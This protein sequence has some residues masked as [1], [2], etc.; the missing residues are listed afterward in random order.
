MHINYRIQTHEYNTLAITQ[1]VLSELNAMA[2]ERNYNRTL[3]RGFFPQN[4]EGD[5]PKGEECD[6]VVITGIP[7]Q[8]EMAMPHYHAQ[9]RLV[10]PHVRGVFKVPTITMEEYVEVFGLKTKDV[11]LAGF[12]TLEWVTITLDIPGE[13]WE[14]LPTIKPYAWLDLP[15]ASSYEKVLYEQAE[16]KFANDANATI[17]QVEEYLAES[18]KDFFN[19][20]SI[21]EEE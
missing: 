2:I 5:I 16:E 17:E 8:V 10:M 3:K 9:G 11:N 19:N 14:K 4:L 12:D 15:E 7:I 1:E 18:E 13:T 21:T 6:R 20:L